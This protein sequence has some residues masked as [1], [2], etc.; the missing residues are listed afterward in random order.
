[1]V[2]HCGFDPDRDRGGL[3]LS[4][5][6]QARQIETAGVPLPNFKL[7]NNFHVLRDLCYLRYRANSVNEFGLSLFV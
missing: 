4:H 1:M 2:R 3:H 6:Q 5:F 7:I